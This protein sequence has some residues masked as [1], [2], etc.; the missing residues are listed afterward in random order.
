MK[1]ILLII[2]IIVSAVLVS[3]VLIQGR[4]TGFGRS[5]SGSSF[6]RRGLER[7]VFK[8]TFAVAGLFIVLSILQLT[9]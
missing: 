5:S 7:F 2:Q 8:M 9:I 6:T 1:N 3:L 4:G